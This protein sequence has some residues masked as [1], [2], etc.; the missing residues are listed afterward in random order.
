MIT[1]SVLIDAQGK[2]KPFSHFFRA[3]GYANADYTYTPPLRRMYDCLSSYAGHPLYMR[4]HN[5]FSL[6]GKGDYYIVNGISDYG[7]PIINGGGG[8]DIVVTYDDAGRLRY[9][10]ELVDRVYD[11]IIGHGMHPIVEAVYMP[12][13]IRK[14][15]QD[16]NMPASNTL[17][18]TVVKEFVSHWVERYGVDEVLNWYFEICNE[19][20][21]YANW[22]KDPSSFFA[23][24]DYFERAVHSV[25]SRFKVGGPAVQQWEDGHRLFEKFLTHCDSGV[26]YC[27]G[28]YGSRLD[29]IS[30]HC[31][32]GIPGQFG[33]SMDYMFNSLREYIT[34]LKQFPRFSETEFFNDESDIVWDG[35][36]GVDYKSWLNFR[37]THYAPGFTCKMIHTYCSVLQDELGVNLTIVDSDNCHLTWEKSLFSGNRSQFTPLAAAPCTDIIR[38]PMFNA[39]QL[40]G[41]LGD[42]R[43]LLDVKDDEFGVKYGVLATRAGKVDYSI[44][45]WNFEDGLDSDVNER[46]IQLKLDHLDS[47]AIYD[48]LHCRIDAAHSNAYSHWV[49]MGRPHQLSAEQISLLRNH[50]GLEL[51]EEPAVHIRETVFEKNIELPMHAVSL[52]LLVK[53]SADSLKDCENFLNNPPSCQIEH[54]VLDTPQVFISWD[55]S[56]CRDLVGYHLYR[57]LA[58]GC[59]VQMNERLIAGA[60]YVDSTVEPSKTYSYTV[61]ALYAD[62]SESPRSAVGEVT[63]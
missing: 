15:E 23:L 40:L 20:E 4:L 7:N 3:T 44:M 29:F 6:H 19:P 25:D 22:N 8:A 46:T 1:K 28:D 42:E 35:N 21:Q 14:S 63:V 32:G 9:D 45:I 58:G 27:T 41:R 24:Y 55:Y 11:I 57:S 12:S 2:S 61:S 62:G 53:R 10:W 37:N 18:E 26:N 33:P 48:V 47:G 43:L 38:K 59:Y 39:F 60:Y 13:A 30:V 16:Y 54:S 36:R 52:I 51:C 49:S 17:W 56:T 31:K 5:I 50:D 34:I